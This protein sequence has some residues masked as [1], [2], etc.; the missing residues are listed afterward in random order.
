M[1]V[2]IY[3]SPIAVC[4]KRVLVVAEELKVPYELICVDYKK[5]ELKSPEYLAHH[6]FGQ[7]PYIEDGG[8]ELF[9]SRAI[10]RYLALK[11]GGVGKLVP[12]QS[13]I[14]ASAKFEQ[15]VNVENNDFE[16]SALVIGIESVYKP[17]QGL[18]TDTAAIEE[19]R[20]VLEG[21]MDGYEALLSK[22]KFLAGEEISLAD[23][24]HLP[25][26]SLLKV[27]GIDCLESSRW[28]NVARRVDLITRVVWWKEIS[29]R[30]T[31]EK[32]DVPVKI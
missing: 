22:T 31:W 18:Q 3:G 28:P 10:C 13:D 5:G 16:P 8:F 17:L 2:K 23:L 11:Y 29:S 12:A 19:K 24:F 25:L 32:V 4:T 1:V 26:G 7:I 9:E 15:A 27:P 20:V 21:K 30:P 6:P 14:E